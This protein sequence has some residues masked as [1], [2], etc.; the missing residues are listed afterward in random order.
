[1]LHDMLQMAGYSREASKAHNQFFSTHVAGRMGR[2]PRSTSN[3]KTWKSFMTDDHTPI[4]LSWNWR[5]H[6]R[7]PTVRYS[8]EPIGREAGSELDPLNLITTYK[9]LAE[10]G[11]LHSNVDL[12]WIS[13]L[14]K[15]LII[16]ELSPELHGTQWIQMSQIFLALDLVAD[17]I[18]LK[19]YILPTSR[20]ALEGR[21]PL[22]IS[23]DSIQS[24][25]D[26]EGNA[27]FD[28]SLV[29]SYLDSFPTSEAPQLEILAVDAETVHKARLKVY[30]RTRQTSFAS[31]VQIF[32]MGGR[33]PR[34]SE[35]AISSLKDL[36]NEL[37]GLDASIAETQPL[38]VNP[39][40][41]AGILHYFS[42]RSG[43]KLPKIKVY[44]P[45]RHYSK[46]DDQ[47]ARGLSK[48][49]D[50][51]NKQLTD[52]PYLQGLQRLCKHRTLEDGLGLHTYISCAF[53]GDD[54]EITAY[55]NPEVGNLSETRS[56]L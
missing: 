20:A 54:L 36:W 44:L 3:S 29:W 25:Q 35:R 46:N 32:E 33:L 51:Q 50:K 55:L 4:E 28:L 6:S 49:L 12:T 15:P 34:L 30:V 10:L 41:T 27:I 16:D 17:Q 22:A 26:G 7:K 40:R 39:H 38:P 13:S 37:F 52:G 53:E 14:V 1:M 9:L 19:I 48:F 42:V 45:V 31:V 21:S 24:L 2:Y 5:P 43:S 18:M 47:V 8:I 56:Q 23:K 11:T